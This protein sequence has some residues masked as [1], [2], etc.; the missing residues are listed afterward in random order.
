MAKEREEGIVRDVVAL[1]KREKNGGYVR[2]AGSSR[3]SLVGGG[4][5]RLRGGGSLAASAVGVARR[6]LLGGCMRPDHRCLSVFGVPVSQT[7][8]RLFGSLA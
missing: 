8:L 3:Q 6:L 7:R 4:C 1:E 2:L 5:M